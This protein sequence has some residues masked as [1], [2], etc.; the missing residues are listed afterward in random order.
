ME[1][2]VARATHIQWYDVLVAH[3]VNGPKWICN[4][5]GTVA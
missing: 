2:L 4:F 1:N 5:K 3:T